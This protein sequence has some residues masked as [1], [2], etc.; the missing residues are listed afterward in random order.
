MAAE[1]RSQELDEFTEMMRDYL[2]SVDDPEISDEEAKAIQHR[3]LQMLDR[4]TTEGEASPLDAGWGIGFGVY[5][6]D[7]EDDEPRPPLSTT[8]YKPGSRNKADSNEFDIQ[9]GKRLA[10]VRELRGMKQEEAAR[11]LGIS[12]QSLG[13]Y[14]RGERT[15]KAKTLYDAARLYRVDGN[16]L[17]CLTDTLELSSTSDKDGFRVTVTY[18]QPKGG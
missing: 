2:R 16:F 3:T 14:E 11:A 8:V 10:K 4:R 17:M 13:K 1:R 18:E 7:D 15:I 6:E 12:A 9:V 5:D